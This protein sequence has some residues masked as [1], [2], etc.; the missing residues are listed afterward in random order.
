MGL[1]VL[2]LGIIDCFQLF[3][4]YNLKSLDTSYNI[5]YVITLF[6]GI[7]LKVENSDIQLLIV[8]NVC[9]LHVMSLDN[10]IDSGIQ[11]DVTLDVMS[12]CHSH[13]TRKSSLGQTRHFLSS[14]MHGVF[15]KCKLKILLFLVLL[16]ELKFFLS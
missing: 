3:G 10:D 8:Y 9:R 2:Y 11:P 4:Y 15:I 14:V 5:C 12:V 13:M 1:T 7:P 16:Q 6:A